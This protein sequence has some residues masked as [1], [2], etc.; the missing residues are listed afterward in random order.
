[1]EM[2]NQ[3]K[4]EKLGSTSDVDTSVSSLTVNMEEVSLTHKVPA[5]DAKEDIRMKIWKLM[6]EKNFVKDY[7][8]P[9]FHKI[10]NF[11][12]CGIAA[13]KL[14]HLR[15]FQLAK[16]IKVN[17]SMAQMH[18]RYLSLQH[19]KT[20]FV[21][22]PAL[23]EEFMLEIDPRTLKKSWQLKRASSKAGAK[24]LGR[25]ITIRNKIKIDLLVVASVACAPNGVRLGKGL[26]YAEIEWGILYTMKAV[27][28]NTIV[29]TTVHDCQ[30]LKEDELPVSMLSL[31][32]LPVDI[33]VTPTRVINVRKRLPKPSEGILWDLITVEQL[34]NIPVLKALQR[35]ISDI[36][37]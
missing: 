25:P 20:L 11:K 19:G 13:E 18:F 1:M 34:E 22:S 14:S 36:V 24:E 8:R 31:H 26:G 16:C 4:A 10:P 35:S 37:T 27:H 6:E 17:P 29:A 28:K 21:P 5:N 33:I 2:K 3:D 30:L 32:D 23:S 12:R 15:E 7:P 9:C